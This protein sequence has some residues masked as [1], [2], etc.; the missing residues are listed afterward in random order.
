MSPRRA[1]LFPAMACA[2]ALLLAGAAHAEPA[3]TSPEGAAA[4]TSAAEHGEEHENEFNW[5]YGFVG[6]KDGVEPSLLYR[7]KG[8]A[9]PFLANIIN[10]VI[11]FTIIVSD[12]N[13]QI[14]EGLKKRKERIVQGM[15]EAGKMKADAALRLAGYEEKLARLDQEIERIRTVTRDVRPSRAHWHSGKRRQDRRRPDG[16]DARLLV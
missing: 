8:M 13:K 4:G 5:A 16:Q 12:C 6:E 11:L 3:A 2:A 14:V 7:P 10:A 9:P 1:G 15:E